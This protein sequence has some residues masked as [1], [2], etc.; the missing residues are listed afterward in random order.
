MISQKDRD[1]MAVRAFA[2]LP[3]CKLASDR[4]DVP[5]HHLGE[6]YV[7]RFRAAWISGQWRWQCERVDPPIRPPPAPPQSRDRVVG[8]IPRRAGLA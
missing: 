5:V 3:P 7:V 1:D 8:R 6:F 2:T 4:A